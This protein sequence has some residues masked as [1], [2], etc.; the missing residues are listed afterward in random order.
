MTTS[1]RWPALLQASNP[2]PPRLAYFIQHLT[3]A[4]STWMPRLHHYYVDHLDRLLG[5]DPQLQQNFH[6]SVWASTTINF[7]PRTCCFP[8]T[9]FS[10]LPFSICSI[11]VAGDYNPMEGGHL[12]LWEC[13][14]VIE[15]SPGSTIL[16]PSAVVTHSNVPVPKSSTCYSITQYSAGGIFHWVDHGF[17]TE[18]SYWE[19][20]PDEEHTEEIRQMEGR[21]QMGMGLFSTKDELLA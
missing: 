8:H 11:Y 13:G 18:E 12:I 3:G 14:L 21:A 15:F 19:A 9:D 2:L 4:F 16:I 20:L 6:N 17:Q 5:Q 7:G 10:N 1:R